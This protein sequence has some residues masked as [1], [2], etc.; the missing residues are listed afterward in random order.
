M[1]TRT[2]HNSSVLQNK[3]L[4][5][6]YQTLID[7]QQSYRSAAGRSISPLPNSSLFLHPLL[8]WSILNFCLMPFHLDILFTLVIF[9]S[10]QTLLN[11]FISLNIVYFLPSR[12]N[13]R[14]Y[15]MFFR[16]TLFMQSQIRINF[17]M[18]E[19]RFWTG[20]PIARYFSIV[21]L[22]LKKCLFFNLFNFLIQVLKLFSFLHL[23]FLLDF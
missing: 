5:S 21:F 10:V 9:G 18:T 19:A 4:S 14:L 13:R 20:S 1:F 12:C 8:L 6:I 2:G 7:H 22:D 17:A 3:K 16:K 23:F 15:E 11:F